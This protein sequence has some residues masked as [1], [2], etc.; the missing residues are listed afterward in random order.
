VWGGRAA[1]PAPAGPGRASAPSSVERG[2]RGAGGQAHGQQDSGA[3]VLPPED[4]PGRP[5]AAV[6]AGAR[7]PSGRD[8]QRAADGGLGAPLAQSPEQGGPADAERREGRGPAS[9]PLAAQMLW[10]SR[11][12]LGHAL[13]G[14]T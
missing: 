6:A 2:F 13:Q 9:R 10:A 5:P 3:C 4:A 1:P 11:L 8:S 7:A 14:V 12:G